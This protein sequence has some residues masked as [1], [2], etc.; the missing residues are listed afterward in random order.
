MPSVILVSKSGFEFPVTTR[1]GLIDAVYGRGA[2]PKVGTVEDNLDTLAGGSAPEENALEPVTLADL[3]SSD[4]PA[5]IALRAAFGTPKIGR[6]FVLLGNSRVDLE[7]Y[8][9][10]TQL[11][12][13]FTWAAQMLRQRPKV[14][15]YKGISAD[16]LTGMAIR[17]DADVA[18]HEPANVFICD[19]I[20]D[21]SAGAT[22]VEVQSGYQT[23]IGLV[24]NLGAR[25]ILTTIAPN[26]SLTA[27]Q[28][29]VLAQTNRWLKGL[30]DPDVLVID[31]AAAVAADTGL[32]WATGYTTDGLH[33]SRRGAARMGRVVA[34]AL[35]PFLP[36]TTPLP[37]TAG[38][39]E[40]CVS[41]PLI[42]GSVGN[43]VPTGWDV[44]P[45][46]GASVTYSIV[47]RTDQVA[48]NWFQA[49]TAA[50]GFPAYMAAQGALNGVVAEDYVE[51]VLEVASD[52][53]W[54]NVTGDVRLYA[55]LLNASN[56]PI[57][58]SYDGTNITAAQH[59]DSGDSSAYPTENQPGVGTPWVFRTPPLLVPA[60]ATQAKLLFEFGGQGTVRIARAALRKVA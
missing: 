3:R 27:G 44:F 55:Q 5:G 24:R 9:E 16:T 43:G 49:T 54:T 53:G 30:T 45:A 37:S 2:Q 8:N 17:F 33:Q 1:K 6:T 32:D 7:D 10:G 14:L 50:G 58:A 42:S 29:V 46:Q 52:A 13:M 11:R 20:N 23:L 15:A 36:R 39:V 21:I 51:A 38:D 25:T 28:K 47:A 22:L 18:A 40:N 60:A 56:A 19:G 34:D 35:D 4:S 31:V 26:A 48:G 59:G 12:G 57:A 41:N